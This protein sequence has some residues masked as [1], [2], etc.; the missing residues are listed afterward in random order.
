[1]PES[2]QDVLLRDDRLVCLRDLD[3]AEVEHFDEVVFAAVSA[4]QDIGW[5][6]IAVD[7]PMRF[8]FGER[9]THL[10]Q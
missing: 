1:M 8:G 7:E 6:D 9:V 10:A 3:D 2:A 4:Y 5:L